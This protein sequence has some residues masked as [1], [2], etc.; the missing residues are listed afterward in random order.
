M[1]VKKSQDFS[2]LFSID[3]DTYNNLI[4]FTENEIGFSVLRNYPNNIKYKSPV[5]SANNPTNKALIRVKYSQSLRE[6]LINI[7]NFC[8]YTNT[9]D[10]LNYSDSDCPTSDSMKLSAKTRKPL[11]VIFTD[12]F[13][14]INSLQITDKE[15]NVIET[16]ELFDKVFR[17][18]LHTI[19]F[20]PWIRVRIIRISRDIIRSLLTWGIKGTKYLLLRM[21]YSF[22]VTLENAMRQYLDGFAEEEIIKTEITKKNIIKVFDYEASQNSVFIV[23]VGIILLSLIS[24][25]FP[26]LL[27]SRYFTYLSTEMFIFHAL[28]LFII[29]DVIM[30]K[31]L[32]TILIKFMHILFKMR[33]SIIFKPIHL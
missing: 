15:G 8:E 2:R 19:E 31:I 9:H 29:I 32:S 24:F 6:I 21:G 5:D 16:S 26:R 10:N 4:L 11:D 20:L 33:K 7:S 27:I 18:H 23:C 25:M 1:Q 14:L 17:K 12:E 30:P 28:L 22:D 3:T 13:Y